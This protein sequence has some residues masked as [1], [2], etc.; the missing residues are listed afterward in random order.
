MSL[1][2]DFPSD[3]NLTFPP[4]FMDFRLF[5]SHTFS[6]LDNVHEKYEKY[7][8][9]NQFWIG[10]DVTLSY[11]FPFWSIKTIL[12]T[13]TKPASTQIWFDKS[14]KRKI[15]FAQSSLMFSIVCDFYGKAESESDTQWF[16]LLSGFIYNHTHCIALHVKRCNDCPSKDHL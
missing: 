2:Y 7:E 11:D 15:Y 8:G 12:D 16:P 14:K 10:F 4:P 1:W 3:V 6:T 5:F 9:P 13:Q